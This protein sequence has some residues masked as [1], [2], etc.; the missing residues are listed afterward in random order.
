MSDD[1]AIALCLL[2]PSDLFSF[3]A[4]VT[5]YYFHGGYERP[6]GFV[7]VVNIQDTNK[8]IQVELN[9]I[10]KGQEEIVEKLIQNNANCLRKV[11]I[12][13]IILKKYFKLMR[14]WW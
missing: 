11:Y 12:K 10:L 6:I 2:S 13:P 5:F 1:G 3:N 8:I 14:E 9:Y 7:E 4:L